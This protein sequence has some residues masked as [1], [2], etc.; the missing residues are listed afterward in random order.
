[1]SKAR[2]A[3]IARLLMSPALLPEDKTAFENVS[4][5]PPSQGV[6][7][8]VDHVP[9]GNV[10]D[11]LGTGGKD[12]E[13]GFLQVSICEPLGAGIG[14]TT[15]LLDLLKTRFWAGLELSYGSQV[16]SVTR[17]ETSPAFPTSTSNKTPFSIYW[18]SRTVR[19]S[20]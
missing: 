14:G 10:V 17:V 6:W 3:L 5:T 4:F 12:M 16:V 15:K 11:T 19:P 1:M 9:A 2:S 20:T 8:E 18:K 7:I 13:M